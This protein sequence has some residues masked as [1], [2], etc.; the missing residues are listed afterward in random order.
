MADRFRVWEKP[1]A[2]RSMSTCRNSATAR[3]HVFTQP[4]HVQSEVETAG[5]WEATE[6]AVACQTQIHSIYAVA[7]SPEATAGSASVA[8]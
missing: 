5:C 8:G 3:R 6:L 2:T 1:I 7:S 4:P